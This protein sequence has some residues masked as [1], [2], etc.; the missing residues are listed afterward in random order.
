MQGQPYGDIDPYAAGISEDCLNLSVWTS[1]GGGT[2]TTGTPAPTPGPVA[3]VTI[4]PK[5]LT[6]R[7]GYYTLFAASPRDDKGVLV[8]GKR[9]SWSSS[10][11][12]VL[13]ASDT[14]VF[15]AKA[16]GSA[17]VYGVID[18]H[19]DSASVVVTVAP[20][21]TSIT[22]PPPPPPVS[23]FNLV[24]TTDGAVA[25]DTSKTQ[26]VGGVTITVTRVLGVRGD[27]LNPAVLAGTVTTDAN[28]VA[29]LQNLP[30][31]SYRF[32]AT[33]GAG[34]PYVVSTFGIGAP[35]TSDVRVRIVLRR[36]P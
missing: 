29:S 3:S 15:Y 18:G 23:A 28:G 34:S 24:L 9:A 35:T 1:T 26:S 14:G 7:V 11:S 6:L 31:G 33:P 8:T 13:V 12:A 19:T 17:K 20:P 22:T 30:G 36:T 16:I 32:V 10:N 27:T 5:T 2:D 21:D 25:A 4:T